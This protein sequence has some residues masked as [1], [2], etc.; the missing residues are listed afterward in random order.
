V[1]ALALVAEAAL[2]KGLGQT[3]RG[4]PYQVMIHVDSAVF[5]D[6]SEE[7]L[8]EF[9]NG[10]G[11]SAETCRRLACNAPQVT[12]SEDTDGNVLDIGRNARKI[13][14]PPWRALMSRD[15]TCRFPGCARTR[16]LEAHHIE[17][18]ASGGETNPDNLVV[19]CKYHH[20][21]VH[22]GGVRVEGRAPRTIVFQRPDGT[23]LNPRSARVPIDGEAGEAL[24]EANRRYGL[25][26]TAETVKDFWDGV[27]MDLHMT[28]DGLLN[29]DNDPLDDE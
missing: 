27:R 12:V 5:A 13:S 17:H 8:C 6:Q 11:I 3:E 9:E 25:E 29:Y 15:R 16:H 14:K 18:W 2:G 28:V 7:G 22:E 21:A 23:V 24:K 20:W 19:L 1:D 26:I 10:E 4:E